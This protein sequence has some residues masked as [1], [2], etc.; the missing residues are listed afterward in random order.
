M[1]QKVYQ[2]LQSNE[3]PSQ[4]DPT[5]ASNSFISVYN[6][7]FHQLYINHE[8]KIIHIYYPNIHDSNSNQNDKICLPFKLFHTVFIKLHAN[9]H[10]GIKFSIKAF[11]QFYFIPFLK[12]RMSIFNLDCLEC[13]QNKHINQK[14]QTVTK[15]TFSEYASYFNY[16]ISMDTKG[17][18]NQPSNQTSNI[19]VIVD[20]F[21]HFVVTVPVKQN[22]AQNAVNSLLHHWITKFGPPV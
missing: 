16:R 18:I 5:I 13:Q 8:T 21:S 7:L 4:I 9:G 6:K 15:Q 1:L 11:N 2:W 17:P 20:P 10:S 14:V 3:R 19:H 12:K 22:N